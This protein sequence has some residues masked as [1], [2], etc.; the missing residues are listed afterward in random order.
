MAAVNFGVP[1]GLMSPHR[2][3]CV[4]ESEGKEVHRGDPREIAVKDRV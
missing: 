3:I 2:Y 4:S 1:Y